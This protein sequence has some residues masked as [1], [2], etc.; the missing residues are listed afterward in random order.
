MPKA[1][2]PTEFVERS[3]DKHGNKFT[4]IMSTFKGLSS[5][6][7]ITCPIHGDFYQSAKNHLYGAN[8]PKCGNINRGK[9]RAH[10]AVRFKK[11]AVAMHGNKYT[12]DKVLYTNKD[13]K[14]TITCPH[15][16]DF[17]QIPHNHVRGSGCPICAEKRQRARYLEEPTILYYI[18]LP[19]FG[20]Y[21]VGITLASIGIR[22]RFRSDGIEYE[23]LQSTLYTTGLE[24]FTVEQFVLHTFN[25]CRYTGDEAPL[26]KG[27][28]TELFSSD[29]LN[30]NKGDKC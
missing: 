23:V 3:N 4:Y 29:I 12:Y 10:T 19:E 1:L 13:T 7:T 25:T 20:L 28:N 24:A 16:G 21:K 8:C 30:L 6:V 22:S 5:K 2:T 17:E 26:K 27:G 15:H 11:K 18:Y 14:V 9:S